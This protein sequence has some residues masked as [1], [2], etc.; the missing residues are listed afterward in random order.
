MIDYKNVAPLTEHLTRVHGDGSKSFHAIVD[1]VG[2]DRLFRDSAGYLVPSG[3]LISI[4]G[5]VGIIPILRSKYLPAALGG[6]PR[7]YKIM[8]LWPDGSYAR[9]A[10]KW[11]DSGDFKHFLTDS[12]Y[13]MEDV[14]KVCQMC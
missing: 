10:A 3:I 8:A 6:V 4:V 2:D 12:E 9:E 11:I 14:L 5:A 1:C 13:A 7:R